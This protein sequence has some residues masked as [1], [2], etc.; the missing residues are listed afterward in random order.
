MYIAKSFIEDDKTSTLPDDIV[1]NEGTIKFCS[2]SKYLGSII[3]NN[4][5]DDNEISTRIKRANSQF[6][7]LKTVL[8]G[9]TLHLH[10]KINLFNAI[11]MNTVLWGC[12]SWTVSKSSENQ[13]ISFQH[14]L[15]RRILKIS[16]YEVLE[17]RITNVEV[18]KHALNSPSIIDTISNRQLLWIGK[19]AKMNTEQIPRKMLAC[20]HT[21]KRKPG[22][23]QL[24]LSNSYANSIKKVIPYVPDDLA[25]EKW[26][27]IAQDKKWPNLVKKW[28][29]NTESSEIVNIEQISPRNTVALEI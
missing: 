16:I 1:T 8:L 17:N 12:E 5:R 3:N 25:L 29:R 4:L 20:W 27:P 19:I 22:R 28:I 14:K 18:R 10:T 7:S 6:R 11:I 15:L 9:K 21:N 23:P 24:N 2:D 26:I 13:L